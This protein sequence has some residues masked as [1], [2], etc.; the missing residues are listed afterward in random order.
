MPAVQGLQASGKVWFQMHKTLAIYD[1]DAE[2]LKHLAEYIKAK[3]PGIFYIKLFT[4]EEALREYLEAEPTD[5]LLIEAGIS[6]ID[7]IKAYCRQLVL[8]TL[9]SESEEITS[10]HKIY[11]Y[12]PGESILKELKKLL[13]EDAINSTVSHLSEKKIISVV[14]LCSARLCQGFSLS[15]W[16]QQSTNQKTLFTTLQAYPLLKELTAQK[17]ESGLSEFLYYLKQKS[18]GLSKKIKECIQQQGKYEYIKA[19]SFGTDIYEIT[20]EDIINWLNLLSQ[21]EYDIFLFEVGFLNQASIRLLQESSVIYLASEEDDITK[22]QT[23]NFLQQLS[24]AGY[25]DII[26]RIV[27][28]KADK[29]GLCIYDE[30]L[31]KGLI[32]TAGREI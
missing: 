25:E 9:T 4:K 7:E 27:K 19:A 28:I 29:Q 1:S 22:N 5:I 14:S 31:K 20:E 13:P 11:K 15:L 30:Y 16:D 10:L 17:G 2:Y 3:A 6:G 26:E 32:G 18:P 23:E 24:F 21:L 12:Q 8:L